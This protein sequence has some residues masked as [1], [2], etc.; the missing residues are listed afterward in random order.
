MRRECRP[1][2]KRR[3]NRNQVFHRPDA[4][5]VALRALRMNSLRLGDEPAGQSNTPNAA[6]A[7]V[8]AP[9]ASRSYL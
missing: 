7:T 6:A 8:A 3:V 9:C 5:E 4:M 2:F 1:Y